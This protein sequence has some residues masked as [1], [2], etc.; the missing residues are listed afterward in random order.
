MARGQGEITITL[1]LLDRLID[2][3][4][5]TRIENPPSR[6]QSLRLLKAAVLRDLEWLLNTRRIVD[7]PDESFKEV[8]KSTYVYGLPDVSMYTMET[9]A[10]RNRLVRQM[11]TAINT[12]EPRLTNVRLSFANK[13]DAAK[14][15]VRIRIEAM[16]RM[17]P[18][19]EP[20]SF[21]TLI[22]L[23]SGTCHLTG[24]GDAG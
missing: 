22:E 17:D 3:E 12:F 7:V 5:E 6:S 1:S 15:D 8:N 19:P 23:K 20:I 14:Q 21:D 10:D 9:V 18:A 16:L 4:P 24:G 13:A 2:H 11:M